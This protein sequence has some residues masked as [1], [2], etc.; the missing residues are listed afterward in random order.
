[1]KLY[2]VLKSGILA[3]LFYYLISVL[4]LFRNADIQTLEEKIYNN[5]ALAIHQSLDYAAIQKNQDDKNKLNEDVA[6]LYWERIIFQ[7]AYPLILLA[8]ILL[9]KES[10][11]GLIAG[12]AACLINYRLEFYAF[13]IYK[14]MT[15]LGAY[16]SSIISSSIPVYLIQPFSYYIIPATLLLISYILFRNKKIKASKYVLLILFMSLVSYPICFLLI[17]F[18]SYVMQ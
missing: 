17:S 16:K 12:S 11:I 10:S 13:Q 5:E 6:D 3:V 14:E 1:M 18:Y 4:F 2:K 9:Y 8:L 7:L 15:E